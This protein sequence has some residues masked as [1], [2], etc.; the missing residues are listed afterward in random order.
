MLIVM[1]ALKLFH[2]C[3]YLGFVVFYNLL[4]IGAV[5]LNILIFRQI[6]CYYDTTLLGM[7]IL[8][9]LIMKFNNLYIYSSVTLLLLVV[10]CLL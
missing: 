8:I 10:I 4:G 1:F 5:V 7:Y 9:Y 6:L 2:Y 3:Y